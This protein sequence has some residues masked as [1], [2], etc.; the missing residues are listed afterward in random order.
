MQLNAIVRKNAVYQKRRACMNC[1]FIVVP[2]LFIL[3]LYGLQR[4]VDDALEDRDNRVSL[5]DVPQKV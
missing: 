1:C 4:L 5:L 3:S 2:V